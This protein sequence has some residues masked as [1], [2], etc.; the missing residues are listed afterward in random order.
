MHALAMSVESL[1]IVVHKYG[2][3]SVADV[4]RLRKVARRVVETARAGKRVCVV[5]SAMGD[6]TDELIGLAK[7]VTPAPPRRELDMLLSCG[8]R[9]SM[10]LLSMAIA[11]LGQEAI[12]FTGSQSGIMTNDRHSG[13]RI[14]EVRPVRIQDELARGRIVIVAGFQGVSYK[15]EI[16]TLGRGGSDTTAVALAAALGAE[17]CEICS[18]VDGVYSADPRV[19]SGAELLQAVSHDEMQELAEH[20]ARVMNPQAVEFARAAGIAIYARA[21]DHRPGEGGTRIGGPSPDARGAVGV[22]GMKDLVRVR[23]ARGAAAVEAALAAEGVRVLRVHGEADGEGVCVVFA[24]D[25]L[26][27][28][29]RCEAKLRAA[30]AGVTIE[31]G[32]GAVTAVGEGL[33]SDARA[34]ARAI[35]RARQAGAELRGHDASPLRLTVY[36]DPQHVDEVVRA[37]HDEFVARRA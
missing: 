23:A 22:T 21:T 27:D 13:A 33:G 36:V 32:L 12:S 20:G 11:E 4:E 7:K 2:G 17:Y 3:S 24:T 29:P 34:L 28:W 9:I 8:E 5:V 15:R 18:D 6:S 31:I 16:T 30:A 25:D 35:A 14:I 26:P 1:P 10:A 19:V 37:L